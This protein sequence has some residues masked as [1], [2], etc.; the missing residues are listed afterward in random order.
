MTSRPKVRREPTEATHHWDRE[1]LKNKNPLGVKGNRNLSL[2]ARGLERFTSKGGY[3]TARTKKSRVGKN[4]R[5]SRGPPVFLGGGNRRGGYASG[6]LSHI[7]GVLK[8]HATVQKTQAK[9]NTK[10]RSW[11]SSSKKHLANIQGENPSE[12]GGAELNLEKSQKR[13]E[14]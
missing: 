13:K 6:R 7:A 11:E 2:A 14:T 12:L 9:T 1:Y 10:P 4:R 3:I 5:L 8:K